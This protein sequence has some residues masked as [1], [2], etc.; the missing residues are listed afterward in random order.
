MLALA[1][2]GVL[3]CTGGLIGFLIAYALL[4]VTRVITAKIEIQVFAN[5]ENTERFCIYGL[6][7]EA[8]LNRL[9][10][11]IIIYFAENAIADEHVTV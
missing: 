5:K 4:P 6:P 1:F 8:S 3:F 9:I 7:I 2:L 11:I 10:L